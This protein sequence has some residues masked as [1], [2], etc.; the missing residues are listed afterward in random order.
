[1]VLYGAEAI[2]HGTLEPKMLELVTRLLLDKSDR[3]SQERALKYATLY[4]SALRAERTRLLAQKVPSAGDGRHL[5]ETEDSL[6]QAQA[7]LARALL[8]LG[9]PEPALAA[10]DEGWAVVP[11][12]DLAVERARALEALGRT[13]EALEAASDAF[14]VEDGRATPQ[15]R[16]RS[17]ELLSEIGAKAGLDPAEK[18]LAA[19][20]RT[21]AL[22]RARA[23]RLRNYDP[24]LGVTAPL[25]F[26]MSKLDGAKMAL[27]QV[28]GKVVVFDFW[29]TWCGPCRVQ[30]PLYEQVKAR[31]QANTDVVFLAVATDEDHGLVKP[32]L[33]RQKWSQEVLLDDGLASFF[34]VNSIPTTIVL[35]K[36]GEIES[37]MPGFVPEKF[38]ETLSQRIEAALADN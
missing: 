12:L 36:R 8:A 28:K 15:G 17:R 38:V 16:L 2:D 5:Q 26:T 13:L 10:A 30:H 7:Y 1:V 29:A 34:R 37:R 11:M 23:A 32:F 19:W 21:Q 20:D 33:E 3:P 31:F 25:E 27:G 18:L 6:G 9:Q 14:L 35:N 22:I 24:N 4:A